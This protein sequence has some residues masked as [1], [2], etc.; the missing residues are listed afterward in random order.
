METP[1]RRGFSLGSDK[2]NAV[3]WIRELRSIHWRRHGSLC[4]LVP[5]IAHIVVPKSIHNRRLFVCDSSF[6]S[7]KGLANAA[8]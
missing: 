5:P 1:L 8:I 2:S 6:C 3:G 7:K 4:R